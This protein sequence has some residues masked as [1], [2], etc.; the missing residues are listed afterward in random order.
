MTQT[1]ILLV[2][3]GALMMMCFTIATFFLKYW[4]HSRERLH[5]MFALAFFILGVNRV[6]L[7]AYSHAIAPVQE[8]HLALY[9]VRLAAFV[10][11][12][13]AIADKNRNLPTKPPI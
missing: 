7:V 9:T 6:L 12:L 8:H 13:L 1:A 4:R 10:I 2:I 5:A 11:I 3:D